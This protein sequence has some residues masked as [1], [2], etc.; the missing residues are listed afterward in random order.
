MEAQEEWPLR[1]DC[2][3]ALADSSCNKGLHA[4]QNPPLS[5]YRPPE[6]DSFSCIAALGSYQLLNYVIKDE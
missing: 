6:L 3:E 2:V 4:L 1:R 5:H